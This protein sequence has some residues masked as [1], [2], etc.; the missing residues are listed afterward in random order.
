MLRLRWR[1]GCVNLSSWDA[2]RIR[3][4]SCV[5]RAVAT[6]QP[7]RRRAA[8]EL[9]ARIVD[10]PDFASSANQ[11]ASAMAMVRASM[12]ASTALLALPCRW[13]MSYRPT[14][15]IHHRVTVRV[16]A[17]AQHN[18]SSRACQA[19]HPCP[20]EHAGTTMLRG[21]STTAHICVQACPTLTRVRATCRED[22]PWDSPDLLVV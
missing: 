19:E 18:M 20:A 17:S 15:V 13:L 10:A 12:L 1:L 4:A 14:Q 5:L 2:C 8:I 3:I 22:F 16:Q 9:T 7:N 11:I 21:A 6:L